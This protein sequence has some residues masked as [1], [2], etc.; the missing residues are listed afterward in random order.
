MENLFDTD[1]FFERLKN[2]KKVPHS[3][4]ALVNEIEMVVGK[5][6]KYNY[7]FWLKQVKNFEKRGGKVSLVLDWLKEIDKYPEEFN[8]G[9]TLTN[10]LS[11]YGRATDEKKS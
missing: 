10:K 7:V 2:K 3:K 11:K 8:R 6:I 5:S 9:G 4:A 1:K